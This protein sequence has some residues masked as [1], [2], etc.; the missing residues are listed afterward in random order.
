MKASEFIEKFVTV[1]GPNGTFKPMTLTDKEKEFVDNCMEQVDVGTIAI[2]RKRA[3]PFYLNT[4]VLK[5]FIKTVPNFKLITDKEVD[6]IP[7]D[8]TNLE[9]FAIKDDQDSSTGKSA[10]I[11]FKIPNGNFHFIKVPY[12][13][14][15]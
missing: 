12:T 7:P 6:S 3:R 14:P 8:A 10:Y 15:E 1:T 9:V 4:E 11:G 13:A 5:D 2:I